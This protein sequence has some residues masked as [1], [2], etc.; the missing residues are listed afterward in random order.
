MYRDQTRH[1][2]G[3]FYH[4]GVAIPF[5]L[6]QH[7]SLA[8][9]LDELSPTQVYGVMSNFSRLDESH[10]GIVTGLWAVLIA[11][12]I[13]A[14]CPENAAEWVVE[15]ISPLSELTT[16]VQ[17]L[18][19]T[20]LALGQTSRGQSEYEFVE[21]CRAEIYESND[22]RLNPEEHRNFDPLR[23]WMQMLAACGYGSGI[24]QPLRLMASMAGDA[25]TVPSLAGLILGALVGHKAL[26]QD[27]ELS[28]DL[29]SV[30]STMHDLYGWDLDASAATWQAVTL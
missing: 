27:E 16:D 25:D 8:C 5:G 26:M 12:A 30:E 29:L 2:S 21:L 11:K 15:Q 3:C 4:P 18:T 7:V 10:A 23:F 20:A 28:D 17:E 9:S 19:D 1:R 6:F 13:R 24:Q 22:H 14:D